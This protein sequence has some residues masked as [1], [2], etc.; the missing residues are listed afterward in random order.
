MNTT[1]KLD[2]P[3]DPSAGRSVSAVNYF[4]DSMNH[5]PVRTATRV[6][7]LLC[8]EVAFAAVGD[9]LKR[10]QHSINMCFWGLDP[11]MVLRRGSASDGKTRFEID[12]I[13][14]EILISKARAG[15]KVR[16]VVWDHYKVG[17][18]SG[19]TGSDDLIDADLGGNNANLA[20]LYALQDEIENLEIKMTNSLSSSVFLPSFHQKTIIVDV[21]NPPTATAFVMGHNMLWPYWST[22]DLLAANPRRQFA[23]RIIRRALT[24]SDRERILQDQAEMQERLDN[25]L[26]ANRGYPERRLAAM[27]DLLSSPEGG[28][29]SYGYENQPSL[30]PYLDI[31]TQIWGGGV[32]DVYENFCRVWSLNG[33]TPMPPSAS[34]LAAQ[35]G[36][37]DGN[38]NTQAQM[39]ATFYHPSRRSIWDLYYNAIS[40]AN[41]YVLIVNQYF[42]YWDL[43]ERIVE[44]WKRRGIPDQKQVPIFVTT[45][46]WNDTGAQQG[47]DG[48][49]HRL[50]SDANVPISLC[51]LKTQQASTRNDIYIH[52]KLLIVDDVFYTIGSANYNWR[53]LQGDCEFNVGVHDPS[54]ARGLRREIMNMLI[55]DPMEELMA[56]DPIEGFNRWVDNVKANDLLA[57]TPAALSHGRAVTYA[58][59]TNNK[60]YIPNELVQASPMEANTLG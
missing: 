28:Y 34:V 11:A 18:G 51:K 25:S 54:Q 36:N 10:A 1:P 46:D 55:G 40:Q 16:I 22:K 56:G 41:R 3:L 19:G 47:H 31:S 50:F 57:G 20:V 35:M 44:A 4:S 29:F 23:L 14:G 43:S 48:E 7:P 39:G 12:D 33:G 45:N 42:R 58:A 9:A 38:A 26:E 5:Y 30:K 24:T 2:Q 6:N 60:W 49:A 13:L 59:D 52:A 32:A 53:S 8:G 27:S 21:E 17:I 15:V 37:P